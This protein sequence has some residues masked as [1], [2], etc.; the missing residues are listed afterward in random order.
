MSES[1][2]CK[3]VFADKQ[4]TT[5][6]IA[7]S[8]HGPYEDDKVDESRVHM[9]KMSRWIKG[10]YI[11]TRCA[12]F[13]LLMKMSACSKQPLQHLLHFLEG[14]VSDACG[15]THLSLLVTGKALA[16]LREYD[17]LLDDPY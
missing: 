12:E 5:T 8:C 7:A 6:I 3:V 9:E 14:D 10:T 4:K 11:G 13:W 15:S 2:S 1:S 16:L 17:V